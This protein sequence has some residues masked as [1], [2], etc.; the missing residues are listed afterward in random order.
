MN[1][2]YW[3]DSKKKRPAEVQAVDGASVI[4]VSGHQ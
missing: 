4:T 2:S 3:Q 1:L